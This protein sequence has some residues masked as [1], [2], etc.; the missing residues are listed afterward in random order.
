MGRHTSLS[1]SEPSKQV[2]ARD[3]H[4]EGERGLGEKGR[5]RFGLC[6]L[7]MAMHRVGECLH[8]C[9]LQPAESVFGCV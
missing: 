2:A 3:D 4:E 7:G 8:A 9:H 1:P 5:E 6:A